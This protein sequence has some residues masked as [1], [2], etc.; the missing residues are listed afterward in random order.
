METKELN[1]VLSD[2]YSDL[3]KL[4]SAREQVETV[5]KSSNNLTNAT[6][7]LAKEVKQIADKIKDET[8][9]VISTFS[10][11]LI[12][13]ESKLNS[14]SETGQNS[15]KDQVGKFRASSNELISTAEKSINELKAISTKT[16]EEKDVEIT[17]TIESINA[18]CLKIQSLIDALSEMDLPNKLDK[19]QGN[20]DDL[21]LS[22]QVLI[23]ET[24]K[25][26]TKNEQISAMQLKEINDSRT[27]VIDKLVAINTEMKL[28]A[29]QQQFILYISWVLII[30]GVILSVYF[31]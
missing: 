19:L 15:I 6:F 10:E 20:S 23:N 7:D 9:T 5:T 13:F 29:K 18:Y 24:N 30:I 4:Q 25:T 2:V 26:Q 22:I 28:V 11:K 16:L 17:K 27:Q 31:K 14:T 3:E 1:K 8:T 12:E 21:K